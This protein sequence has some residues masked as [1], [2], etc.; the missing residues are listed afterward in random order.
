MIHRFQEPGCLDFFVCFPPVGGSVGPL[1]FESSLVETDG[2]LV[3]VTADTLFAEIDA[4][5][6]AQADAFAD[7][8]PHSSP[9]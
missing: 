1:E 9:P 2:V 6:L 5:A 7:P 3:E 8:E 4:H